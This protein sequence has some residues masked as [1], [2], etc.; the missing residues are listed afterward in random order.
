MR[1]VEKTLAL[2]KPEAFENDIYAQILDII[3]QNGFNIKEIVYKKLSKQEAE[4]FYSCHKGKSFFD[5]YVAHMCSG[6]IA[7]LMLERKDA[8]KGWRELMG[9]TDPSKAAEGTIRKRFATAMNRN[10]V[11]GSDS[12]EN[13]IRELEFFFG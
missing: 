12:I 11:H 1:K 9:S 5:S 13:A 8:V 4:E 6:K 10:M 2:L 3:E 7:A